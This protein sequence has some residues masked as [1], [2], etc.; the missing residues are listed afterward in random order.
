MDSFLPLRYKRNDE[1]SFF[2]PSPFKPSGFPTPALS[3]PKGSTP[4]LSAPV[5]NGVEVA[6][7]LGLLNP[8]LSLSKGLTF[9]P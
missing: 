5:L 1:L 2:R 6:E 9:R 4:E 3:M 7:V 8:T